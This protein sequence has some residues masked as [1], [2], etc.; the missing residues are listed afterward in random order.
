MEFQDTQ[1][2]QLK[3]LYMPGPAWLIAVEPTLELTLT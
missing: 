3:L 1:Q 2:K